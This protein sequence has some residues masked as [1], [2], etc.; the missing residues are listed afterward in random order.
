MLNYSLLA[1][2]TTRAGRKTRTGARAAA[3]GFFF[4]QKNGDMILTPKV[5]L[6]LR[7]SM[8]LH[9]VKQFTKLYF[10]FHI[11]TMTR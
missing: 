2:E 6:K 8:Y 11:C 3:R 7:G 1:A 5:C 4:S 10:D 9:W